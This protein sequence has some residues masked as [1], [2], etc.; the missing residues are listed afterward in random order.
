MPCE[1]MRHR[2]HRFHRPWKLFSLSGHICFWRPLFSKS[3]REH[4]FIQHSQHFYP[5]HLW[6]YLQK[7]AAIVFSFNFYKFH[8]YQTIH[9]DT[10]NRLYLIILT[11]YKIF[12]FINNLFDY[13]IWFVCFIA[14]KS[15]QLKF[16][17]FS[18]NLEGWWCFV[19]I[20]WLKLHFQFYLLLLS[21]F[22]LFVTSFILYSTSK[23]ELKL[24]NILQE[25]D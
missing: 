22:S 19:L 10:Y 13:N 3:K 5:N 15:F 23:K 25:T 17:F 8:F 20:S 12:L 24:W 14:K 11:S 2:F 6:I 9:I 1:A 21:G 7:R 4:N 16:L 18:I